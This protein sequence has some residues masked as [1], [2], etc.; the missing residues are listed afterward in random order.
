MALKTNQNK[1][2]MLN[3]IYFRSA[4]ASLVKIGQVFR[5]LLFLDGLTH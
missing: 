4:I 5:A 2:K 3:K 1:K